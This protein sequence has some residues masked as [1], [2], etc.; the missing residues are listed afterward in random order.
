VGDWIV[1]T[2]HEYAELDHAIIAFQVSTKKMYVL[3]E[4]G[5]HGC[6]ADLS[7]DDERIC[8][9][10]NDVQI[11]AAKFDPQLVGRLPVRTFAQ[12]PPQ[13]GSVYYADWSP[14]G[15]YIA[16]SM[17]SDFRVTDP[18]TGGLWDVFVA[19]A[20]GG[21]PVQLTFDHSNNKQPEFFLC[22]L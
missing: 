20:E 2:V 6:R 7:W 13:R 22:T 3:K 12:A 19:R 14:D 15:K 17:N 21:P 4:S 8:W 1:A 5:I 18:K 9:N 10:A 16:Y 11:G